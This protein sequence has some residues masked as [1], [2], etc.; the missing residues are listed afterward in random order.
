M[1]RSLT[2][3]GLPLLGFALLLAAVPGAARADTKG[4]TQQQAVVEAYA[5]NPS[6][7]VARQTV[8]VARAGVQ[9]AGL[10]GNPDL[11]A[12]GDWVDREANIRQPIVLGNGLVLQRQ[13]A[14][15]AVTRAELAVELATA[16]LRADVESAYASLLVAQARRQ[17]AAESMTLATLFS[18]IARKRFDAGD[19]ARIEFLQAQAVLHRVDSERTEADAQV[20]IATTRLAATGRHAAAVVGGATRPPK[21]LRHARHRLQRPAP[22]AS[23]A[24]RVQRCRRQRH[25]DDRPRQRP[26]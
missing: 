9:G 22:P 13:L 5:H 8:A 16:G 12:V 10:L 23:I 11:T 2:R 21:H 26:C 6:L 18:T 17:L 25:H 15:L 1:V 3:F 20:S 14:S 19:V 7:Q 24:R 4:L